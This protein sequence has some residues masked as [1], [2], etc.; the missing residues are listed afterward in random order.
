M[1]LGRTNLFFPG[2]VDLL[3]VVLRDITLF[4]SIIMLCGIDNILQ[5]IPHIHIE[6]EKYFEEYC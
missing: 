2:V 6:F 4:R 3:L 1:V 5:N